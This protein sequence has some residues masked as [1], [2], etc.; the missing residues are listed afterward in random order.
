M[1]ERLSTI[2]R[3][4]ESMLGEARM[5]RGY[6]FAKRKVDQMLGNKIMGYHY[7]A[8]EL[9]VLAWKPSS[10]D[11]IFIIANHF[12]KQLLNTIGHYCL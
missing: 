8:T 3:S 5:F 1:G 7:H 2:E 12:S 4:S 6:I 10:S 9:P 11:L